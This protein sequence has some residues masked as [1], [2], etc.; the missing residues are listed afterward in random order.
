MG[1]ELNALE[2]GWKE[3]S[4]R[5]YPITTAEDIR[6]A[7]DV[8]LDLVNCACKSGC[9]SRKCSCKRFDLPCTLAC[10]N[11]QGQDCNNTG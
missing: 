8:V 11:C 9:T 4:G 6:I 7:P 10:V 2:W 5:Y 1:N 3:V